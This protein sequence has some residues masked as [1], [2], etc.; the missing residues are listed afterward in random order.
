MSN[1]T[2][3]VELEA[4][5]AIVRAGGFRRAAT[6]RGVSASA[7]SHSMRSLEQRLGVRLLHRTSR[8]V[9]L[10]AAGEMLVR[11][12]EPRFRGIEEAIEG[13]NEFR[14]HLVGRVRITALRDA[15]RLL[16]APKLPAFLAAFP[17]IEVEIAVDDKF[18]DMVAEGFDAGIRYGGTVPEGMIA[19][20]L[21][22]S[23]EWVIVGS[24]GYLK[25]HGHPKHPEDL[26]CHKCI[27]IRLGTDRIYEWEFEHQ[28]K[29]LTIDVPGTIILDDSELSIRM[30]EAGVGLFYCLKARVEA[31]LSSGSLVAVLPEWISPG[32]GF[33]AY[34]SSHRQVPSALRAFLDHLRG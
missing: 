22:D 32:P 30:A 29:R 17:E 19:S 23:L 1:R 11:E 14:G 18:V 4:F 9:H 33:H 31:Q 20:R 28:E 5:L 15:A 26:S 13:L 6:I 16:L 27:R 8:S 34:Y 2:D 24:P 10:T 21:S 3:L 7:L 25:D 12:L